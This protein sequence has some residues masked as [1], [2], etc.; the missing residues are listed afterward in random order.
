[1][2]SQE[3]YL[4]LIHPWQA[5]YDE[6]WKRT[7]FFNPETNESTWVLPQ[8]VNDR[9]QEYYEEK[10]EEAFE[11]TNNVVKYIPPEQRMSRDN[12]KIMQR[13]ARQQVEVSLAKNFA[14]KQG[15]EEYNIWYDKYISDTKDKEREKA[16]TRCEPEVDAGY[17]KAD[18]ME[19]YSTYFCIH[20]A[21]GCCVEGANCKYYHRIPTL[22]ECEQI[23]QIRDI[24]GRARFS[25]HREDMEGVGS[26]LK[27]CRTLYVTDFRMPAGN[28]PI[29]QMYEI[30]WRH[31]SPWG[32]IEDINVHPGKAEATIRYAHR[33]MAEFAKVAMSNQSL[34]ADEILVVKWAQ[35]EEDADK[36]KEEKKED[37][38]KKKKRRRKKAEP[39]PLIEEKYESGYGDEKEVSRL[40][41][42]EDKLIKKRKQ[43]AERNINALTEIF[44]RIEQRNKGEDEESAFDENGNSK[45]LDDDDNDKNKQYYNAKYGYLNPHTNNLPLFGK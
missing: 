34:D 42:T 19:K 30:L 23:D 37:D 15:D 26:F 16:L 28:D 4:K 22:E 9:I 38:K 45:P 36:E 14:Y 32:D 44:N 17:T 27:E 7:Y 12:K 6:N 1:M 41:E 35:E 13:P 8:E 40:D 31:F 21:R 24:F 5:H 39:K 10:L 29:G 11:E 18:K 20:F 43:E 2:I 3:E 25:D 33:C